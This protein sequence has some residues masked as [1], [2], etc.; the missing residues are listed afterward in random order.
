MVQTGRPSILIVD[1][2]P[3]ILGVYS[4]ALEMAGYVTQISAT[5][6]AAMELI[7][8][9]PPAAILL[10]LKMPYVNG[11]GFLYRLRETHPHLPVAII[12][13]VQA[14]TDATLQEIR[15]LGADL[16][17]KPLS[18]SELHAVVRDLLARPPAGLEP[19]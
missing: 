11:L 2:Q 18:V 10:D 17:F 4:K 6:Q 14:H 19:Q 5:A 15:T 13:G 3:E 7:E 16:R 1:D 12:T 9:A 8:A